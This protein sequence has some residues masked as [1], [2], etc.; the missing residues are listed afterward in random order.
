MR[1]RLLA[2]LSVLAAATPA[3]AEPARG[4]PVHGR[5][6]QEIGGIWRLS[7]DRAGASCRVLLR[8][9]ASNDGADVLGMP[10]ACRH[11]MPALA[12]VGRWTVPDAAHVTLADPAGT[13]VLTL[14]ETPDHA[15][16]FAA[17][18]PAGIYRLARIAAEPDATPAPAPVLVPI[19]A[20]RRTEVEAEP[21]RTGETVGR[22]AVMR[23]ARDTGCMLTL[24]SARVAGGNR[25]QL[26][27]GCRD[28]GIVVFD[29][30][31]WSL[32]KGDL[33][34]TARA[35]HK[36]RLARHGESEWTK[37]ASEGGKPLGLKKL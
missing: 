34:L 12:T 25:A 27:P 3:Q 18:T 31:A 20:R 15:G 32:V 7:L 17:A 23:G 22:Y 36:A 9:Q 2:I 28:Q 8:T 14:A 4:Q 37:D 1:P 19:A 10:A 30:A 16:A 26:A 33:V 35:G 11:A 24:D 29:P 21:A 13:A 5:T 6:A